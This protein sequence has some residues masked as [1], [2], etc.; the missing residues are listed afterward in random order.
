M[1]CTSKISFHCPNQSA[2]INYKKNDIEKYLHV[3]FYN[4]VTPIDLNNRDSIPHLFGIY[5]IKS[6]VCLS[7]TTKTSKKLTTGKNVLYTIIPL[8]KYTYCHSK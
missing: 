8:I 3:Y 1:Y 2:F 5:I 4:A 7:V 6:R